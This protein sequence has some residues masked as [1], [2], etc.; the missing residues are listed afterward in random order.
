MNEELMTAA[1]R[2]VETMVPKADDLEGMRWHGWALR[3]SFIAG[4]LWAVTREDTRPWETPRTWSL[5]H[6][7][8]KTYLT[9]AMKRG[10]ITIPEADCDRGKT[11]RLIKLRTNPEL[12]ARMKP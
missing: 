2:H 6:G 4:F 5:R 9:V 8:H 7:R 3:E 10:R 1:Y 11:G 12:E